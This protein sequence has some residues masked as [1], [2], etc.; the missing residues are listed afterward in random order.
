MQP[1]HGGI[2]ARWVVSAIRMARLGVSQ[3]MLRC[4]KM[5]GQTMLS[6]FEDLADRL[7]KRS[8]FR[9]TVAALRAMPLDVALDLDLYSG[10]AEKIARRVVYGA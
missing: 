3:I 7:K 9:R 6:M 2:T 4:R 8:R 10:D 5:K 1:V